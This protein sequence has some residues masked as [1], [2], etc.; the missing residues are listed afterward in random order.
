M[1]SDSL[2]AGTRYRFDRP[3]APPPVVRVDLLESLDDGH[4]AALLAELAAATQG[5]PTT[6][7]IGLSALTR[8]DPRL[9]P[10]LLALQAQI[11]GEGGRAVYVSDRPRLRGVALWVIHMSEDSQA[12]IVPN[13]A[14]ALEW[15]RITDERVSSA[16]ERTL[17]RLERLEGE[18]GERR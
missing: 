3:D 7:L 9:R 12:K 5:A 15:L 10:F 16:E 13:M 1:I 11:S 2:M 17:S 4:E 18:R 8:Y 14:A 6:V